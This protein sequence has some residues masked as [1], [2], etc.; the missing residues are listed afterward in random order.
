MTHFFTHL[1]T[2]RY[3]D[4]EIEI[5][6]PSLVSRIV[7]VRDQIAKEWRIDL[8]TFIKANEMILESYHDK[9]LTDRTD[10]ECEDFDDPEDC[11]ETEQLTAP[12]S[13]GNSNVY[14]R[15]AM[16]LLDNTMVSSG[17]S[18]PNRKGNFDL[19]VLLAT[20]ESVHRVLRE[21]RKSGDE[22]EVSFEW[23]RQFYVD[24]IPTF[25][26]GSHEYHRADD[27]MEE[28]LITPPSMKDM[29][30]QVGLID[31]LRIAEDIIAMR[32]RVA[33]DWKKVMKA[34]PQDHM[35]LQRELLAV[36]MG[37]YNKKDADQKKE[38]KEE[39]EKTAT[40]SKEAKPTD[41][42]VGSFE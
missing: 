30:G 3:V 23:L 36:R 41:T 25:F 14:D 40:A 38:E 31:P 5:D 42:E 11:F 24:R 9:H 13:E 1:T 7:S 19:M 28:L 10:E 35:E 17:A 4:F 33:K 29:D 18:S 12:Y 8:D 16:Y 20:Q 6:P 39:K 26:D 37:K 15:N 27:F 22:R 32:T 2:Q 34:V 21:Y